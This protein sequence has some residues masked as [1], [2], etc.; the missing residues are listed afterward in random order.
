LSQGLEGL[1]P[2]VKSA[3][4]N[5]SFYYQTV[6][7]LVVE[8]I[9][10]ERFVVVNLGRRVIRSWRALRPFILASPAMGASSPYGGQQFCMFEELAVR[11]ASMT[12]AD[13][14]R[15]LQLRTFDDSMLPGPME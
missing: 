11:S 14:V 9:V 5:V 6:A 2:D 4:L 10:D 7:A 3:A 12:N 15:V 13:V 8:G 1:P